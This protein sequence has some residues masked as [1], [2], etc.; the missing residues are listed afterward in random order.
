LF[1]F[2]QRF[3]FLE[4]TVYWMTGWHIFSDYPFLGVGLGNSGYFFA[5]H[6]PAI[7]WKTYEIRGILFQ[8]S[9]LANI[10]SF[11]YRLLAETGLAGFPI[12]LAF[13]IL[14]W[15]SARS[16][17]HSQNRMIQS[18]SLAGR[19]AILAFVFEGL[20]VDSFGLPYLWVITGLLASAGW[21]FRHPGDGLVS[22]H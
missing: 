12:F 15:F 5:S 14:L 13:L 11:W 22:A 18:V 9:T 7:G 8:N 3:A 4:R 19:L 20:S 1:F 6:L 16:S 10:K 21:I 17:Q 2:G